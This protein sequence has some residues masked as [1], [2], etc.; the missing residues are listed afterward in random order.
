MADLEQST[1]EAS[2]STQSRLE[3][4]VNLH[5]ARG[6]HAFLS[7]LAV[8]VVVA[9]VFAVFDTVTRDF[10]GFFDHQSQYNV[11]QQIISNIL[12]IAIAGEIGLLLLYHRTTA[13]I[14]V[15]ILVVARKIVSPETSSLEILMSV[16]ALCALIITRTYFLPGQPK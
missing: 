4:T 10:A 6:I 16:V 11:L 7:V 14:E 2:T 13:A 8:V 15:I 3:R 1:P 9:A 12:L 5:V